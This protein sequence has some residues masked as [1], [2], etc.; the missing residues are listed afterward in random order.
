MAQSLALYR[1]WRPLTFSD[2]VGQ[3]H[4]TSA[5]RAQVSMGRISHA[6]LFTGTRGTGKTTCAKILARAACCEHPVNGEPCNECPSCLSILNDS[7]SDFSEIDAASNN[8]VGDIRDIR[9]E[10]MFSPA[11]LSRRVYIVDEVHMLSQSAF[12]ALLKTLEE[13]PEHVLF[14]L[15]TTEV[16]K[17]P[18]TILSRCQRFDFRRIPPEVIAQRLLY[19]AKQEKYSLTESAA[20]TLAALGDGSM[21]D[22]IS[23]YDRCMPYEGTVDDARVESALGLPANGLVCDIFRAL[24]SNDASSALSVFSELYQSGKDIISLF[25]RLF[26]YIRDIYI[27]KATNKPE[28]LSYFSYDEVKDAAGKCTPALLEFYI[29]CLSDLL[30]KVTRISVR[31]SDGEICLFKM[32]M[33]PG[34]Y[35]SQPAPAAMP[36]G[37][38]TP[39]AAPK[40]TAAEKPEAP[41]APA[42]EPKAN[43]GTISPPPPPERRDAP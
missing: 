17:I 31:R 1:K 12:N 34:Y 14:I 25:D 15:A 29:S 23:L 40:K 7:A 3:E 10:A 18:Q 13:P 32:A 28:Y 30:S 24:L 8:S 21:R 43:A 4:I 39:S 38:Q 35:A 33:G 22:S 16:H 9:E 20:A 37:A 26:A 2:V 36:A 19:I 27:I 11:V 6:Y 41:K 5:L 42:T